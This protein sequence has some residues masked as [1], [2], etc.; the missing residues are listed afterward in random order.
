MQKRKLYYVY[1]NTDCTEGRGREVIA[2]ICKYYATA[3]RLARG[4]YVQG[5]DGPIKAVEVDY[6]PK[7]DRYFGEIIVNQGTEKDAKEDQLHNQY[8][9]VLAQAKALGLSDSDIELIKNFK[10]QS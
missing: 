6:D 4:I 10:K 8:D 7:T 5:L 3:V 2:H 9:A 1:T